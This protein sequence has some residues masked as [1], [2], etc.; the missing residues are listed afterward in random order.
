MTSKFNSRKPTFVLPGFPGFPCSPPINT[1]STHMSSGTPGTDFVDYFSFAPAAY[2]QSPAAFNFN[3]VNPWA[4]LALMSPPCVSPS[5]L[6]DMSS[7]PSLG[8]SG[9]GSVYESRCAG[10]SSLYRTVLEGN[11]YHRETVAPESPNVDGFLN[12]VPILKC[13]L[14]PTPRSRPSNLPNTP[15][16]GPEGTPK[17]PKYFCPH[18]GCQKTFFSAWG[19]N[20]HR[21][22]HD[23][24][25]PFSCPIPL[26]PVRSHRLDAIKAHHRSHARKI[27]SP[28]KGSELTGPPAEGYLTVG[29]RS[30]RLEA[31]S[32][33]PTPL[34]QEDHALTNQSAPS[35]VPF[36]AFP[37]SLPIAAPLPS[38]SLPTLPPIAPIPT[39]SAS[40]FPVLQ[41]AP[42]DTTTSAPGLQ[43]IPSPYDILHAAEMRLAMLPSI[44]VRTLS[45]ED[46]N[47]VLWSAA[48]LRGQE[49]GVPCI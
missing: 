24:Y 5:G 48:V 21:R 41:S 43:G 8:E 11:M 49:W 23:N 7:A 13:S 28:L 29:Y 9:A 46:A 26:C 10:E 37:V 30:P 16:A 33:L 25:R 3:P 36:P 6:S 42:F 19:L 14:P 47:M 17:Q 40:H 45:L 4:A 2:K 22:L 31:P 1:A 39:F 15:P 12:G 38:P 32:L 20:R 18:E 44:D 34:A 35:P 27:G